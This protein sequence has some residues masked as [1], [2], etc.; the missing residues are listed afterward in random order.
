M[1]EEFRVI[2]VGNKKLH[3]FFNP[4]KVLPR[5]TNENVV[6]PIT[7]E[8]SCGSTSDKNLEVTEEKAG[9]TNP[10]EGAAGTTSLDLEG[11]R[12]KRRKTDPVADLT[13]PTTQ[14]TRQKRRVRASAGGNILNHLERKDNPSA[15]ASSINDNDG[16]EFNFDPC[17]IDAPA[18]TS[19]PKMPSTPPQVVTIDNPQSAPDPTQSTSVPPKKLLK[20]NPKTGTIGS[21]PKPQSTATADPVPKKRGRKPKKLIVPLRYGEDQASRIR[22]GHRIEA[23]I[24]GSSEAKSTEIPMI[25]EQP[26][27]ETPKKAIAYKKSSP[28]QARS[29]TPNKPTHPFFVSKDK[30]ETKATVSKNT[31]ETGKQP[32][33][34]VVFTSTPCSPKKF[35]PASQKVNLP[36][37]GLKPGGLKVPGAQRPAWPWKGMS[38][39]G[40]DERPRC[41][42][43]NNILHST[44]RK[45]S[46]GRAIEVGTAESVLHQAG[47][48]LNISALVRQLEDLNADDFQPPHPLLR[49]PTRYF[50]SGKKL[51]ARVAPQLRTRISPSKDHPSVSHAYNSLCS[52][53]SAFDKATC[54]SNTWT[55]K[56]A[57][58]SAAQVLQN[59]REV[60]MLRDW[61]AT[62]KVQ[63][64]DTGLADGPKSKLAAGLPKR[65]RKRQKLDGFVVSSDEEE[66]DEISEDEDGWTPNT[67]SKPSQKTVVK[68][69]P[70]SG[71]RLTNAVLLSG[72]HGCGKTATVFAI[73]KE[74]DFEVFEISPG[75]RRNG[76]DIVEKVGDMTRN[77][78]VQHQ[79]KEDA[80]EADAV[81]DQVAQDLKSGKQGMMTNFFKSKTPAQDSKSKQRSK[82][83]TNQQKGLLES[84]TT[85]VKSQ[86]Q[87]QS[88][89][90]LEEVDVL[91]DE[92]K[93]FWA[94]IISMISQSKR[95]FIMTCN[96]ENLVPIQ[97][98]ALHGIFRFSQPP[99]DLA[100]DRLIL[101]AA[102]EGHVL[103]RH[104]VE[105]LYDSRQHDLRACVNEL[106][107][108]CQFG[109]GDP[110]GGFDWFYP[111][112]PKGSDIDE[113]GNT[114]RVISEGTYEAGM[115][116]VG[117]DAV[118]ST[119]CSRSIEEELQRQVWHDWSIDLFS[120]Q[121]SEH[122]A[123]WATNIFPAQGS[124]QDRLALLE[125]ADKFTNQLS[126]AD[127]CSSRAFAELN[128]VNM[129]TSL[130]ALP[131]KAREDF[132][133]GQQILEASP[134]SGYDTVSADIST[135]MRIFARSQLH[136]SQFTSKPL[137][138]TQALSAIERCLKSRLDPDP[139]ITR[140]D[141]SLA[142]DPLAMSEKTMAGGYL[143][144]SVFD[145]TM[146]LISLDVAPY[147]RSIVSYDQQLQKE[148]LL[149][150]NLISEGGTVAK[151]RM[152]NTRSA[153]SAME[154]GSRASTRREK[155][156]TADINP[157]LVMQTGGDG[158]DAL[159][160]PISGEQRSKASTAL[161][162]SI[163]SDDNSD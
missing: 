99:K 62:L 111:R 49:L 104:A 5:H 121:Q 59:G 75:S 112:W 21:P 101:I 34:Q 36:Q 9:H 71:G 132:I 29:T 37:F 100:V 122:F 86:K 78:L 32:K 153:Y 81:D 43:D 65:G 145:R 156:F 107:Y 94:T 27:P 61:L 151:K 118:T 51:Q 3:P 14:N 55:Q 137:C 146:T 33:R 63:A 15:D 127:L 82:V 8:S 109:V 144:P 40:G 96:D 68:S 41:N 162:S 155:Y 91:Y 72:P 160:S 139:M 66:M 48:N 76:K 141:Y 7:P 45:K 57:P 105:A 116:W 154:G 56:Y 19:I 12:R 52:T 119:S 138:E 23:I 89:I 73:A 84:N 148:R 149:R 133:I 88:L 147:I 47:A 38:H 103:S 30:Q 74:L 131:S 77:H 97:N 69:A 17:P 90:L 135:T 106:N 24:R 85:A 39:V 20:F 126:D 16:P 159:R 67:K 87:K 26:Q 53:L 150:S 128:D 64:V 50:E 58:S 108:W 35:Q 92:D 157:H 22:I 125:A 6:M 114:V 1:A 98:L 60:E 158:W 44:G 142:F 134:L 28:K 31:E 4:T 140:L 102:N 136:D 13:K 117:R 113:E 2:D 124:Q 42:A 83:N 10:G 80:S 70:K 54:E 161:P 79:Q 25:Q 95:P 163:S 46:K 18:Q 115:G 93:Q 129:D 143:D 123:S 130:P 120:S 11:R 110:R 152:R